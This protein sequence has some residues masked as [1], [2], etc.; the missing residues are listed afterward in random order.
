MLGC[1]IPIGA[2]FFVIGL[3]ATLA[4]PGTT[5]LGR[6][7]MA[8][9]L[10]VA[11]FFASILLLLRDRAKFF[12]TKKRVHERLQ[13][14]NDVADEEFCRD[15]EEFCR[16]ANVDP[17]VVLDV[18]QALAEF[19]AVS[20]AKIHPYDDLRDDYSYFGLDPSLHAFVIS[21]VLAKRRREIGPFTFPERPIS[22]VGDFVREVN[23]LV[24]ASHPT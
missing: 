20:P 11:G 18:R 10:G 9:A 22:S 1:A 14:R 3:L 12:A 13:A 6:I 23:R 7:A 2:V 8:A 5:I 15:A 19:F 4:T 17:S 24:E 21:R 16:D